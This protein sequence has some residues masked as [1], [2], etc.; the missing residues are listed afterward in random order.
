MKGWT[1]WTIGLMMFWVLDRPDVPG[2]FSQDG[3]KL[4]WVAERLDLMSEMIASNLINLFVHLG[5][6]F[7]G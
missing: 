6:S 7:F 2:A 5:N 3:T 1:A 4:G